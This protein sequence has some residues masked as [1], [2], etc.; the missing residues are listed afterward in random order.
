METDCK[1]WV[2][3]ENIGRVRDSLKTEVDTVERARLQQLLAEHIAQ[4]NSI[5]I[6][7]RGPRV[8]AMLQDAD[9]AL[10]EQYDS[11]R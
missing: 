8:G 11:H 9:E 10:V 3:Y 4:L 2:I 7:G 6:D 1:Y 5:I